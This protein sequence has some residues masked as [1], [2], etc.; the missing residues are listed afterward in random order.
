[1]KNEIVL[2]ESYIKDRITF[3]LQETKLFN[4]EQ[5]N[6]S[7]KID[8][9]VKLIVLLNKWNKTF[10]LTALKNID[11]QIVLHVIDSAV[12]APLITGNK[13]AD[14]GTGA[15]F[16]GLVL[17]ILLENQHFTLIDSI[18]KKTAFVK[19]TS[20]ELGLNNVDVLTCRCESIKDQNF[21]CI[22]CRAFA[23]LNQIV[24][25]CLPILNQNGKF[26]AM[27]ANLTKEEIDGV[28][29]LV[30]ITDIIDL[31]VPTLDAKRS[32]VIMKKN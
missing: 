2:D 16:P 11:E 28:S 6:F 13:I 20:I 3:L 7:E 4:L 8:K 10:N 25:W 1:M 22:V 15:G 31:K 17:A 29:S 5:N 14:V 9:L 19:S 26:V 24:S 12:V 27:K 23:S 32:A 30:K 18:A 21:D